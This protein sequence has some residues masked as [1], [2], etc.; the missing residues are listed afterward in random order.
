MAAFGAQTALTFAVGGY[1]LMLRGRLIARKP[2]I[3]EIKTRAAR[4][5]VFEA[6]DAP[7]DNFVNLLEVPTIFFAWAGILVAAPSAVTNVSQLDVGLAW[8]FV[9]LRVVH[10][11]YQV[12]HGRVLHRFYAYAASSLILAGGVAKLAWN[13]RALAA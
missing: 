7:A 4:G 6:I 5:R 8:A 9:A 11:A 10:S 13:Y 3:F 1:S 2:E 12:S